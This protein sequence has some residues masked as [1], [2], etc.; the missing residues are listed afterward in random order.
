MNNRMYCKVFIIF[1]IPA[2]CAGVIFFVQPDYSQSLG[3]EAA[4]Y[5]VRF[6]GNP[7]V[8]GGESLT[9]GADCSGFIK[10]VYGNFGIETVRTSKEFEKFGIQV[11]KGFQNKLAEPGDIICY[12]GHV[13][14]YIGNG[15][16]VHSSNSRD[17]IKI[18]PVNH[19]KVLCV[20]RVKRT[21]ND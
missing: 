12:D 17:G 7:Y 15:Q 9:E 21:E 13:G 2:V 18:S 6:V 3:E 4:E 1:L 19:K 14:L 5:A 20:R 11:C 8:Y 16:I 10:A